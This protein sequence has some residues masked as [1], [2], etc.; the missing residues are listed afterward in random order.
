VGVQEEKRRRAGRRSRKSIA[1]NILS[2]QGPKEAGPI[3]NHYQII[4]SVKK[5]FLLPAP[6]Y[7][8]VSPHTKCE[9]TV[10]SFFYH[11]IYFKLHNLEVNLIFRKDFRIQKLITHLKKGFRIT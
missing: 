4:A 1:K 7:F 8:L 6:P 9:N 11:P 2:F 5:R 10:L 3:Q